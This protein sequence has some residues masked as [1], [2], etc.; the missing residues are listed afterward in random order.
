MAQKKAYEVENFLKTRPQ[1][2]KILL[3]YG[4]DKGLAAEYAADFAKNCGIKPDDPFAI[5]KIDSDRLDKNP[6]ALIDEAQ[7][8]GFFGGKKVVW[9]A[10]AG[11]GA[12]DGLSE[13]LKFLLPQPLADCF[14][15]IEAGDLKKGSALRKIIEEAPRA[16]ALPC[17]SDEGQAIQKLIET[18]LQQFHCTISDEARAVLQANLGNDRLVSRGELEKLCLYSRETGHI[19]VEAVRNSVSDERALSQ[20]EV[21]DAVICGDISAFNRNFDRQIAGGVPAFVILSAVMRQFQQFQLFRFI[22]EEDHKKADIAIAAA[23][24][25]V[26][27]KRRKILEQAL[28]LWTSIKINHAIEKLHKTLLNS[29]KNGE[30]GLIIIRQSLL[31][32]TIAAK[33]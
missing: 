7:T 1:S 2:Y 4:P 3:I 9:V 8:I 23:R 13:A 15:V 5:V 12:K 14:I 30:L 18:V 22:M 26:F 29:R 10:Y 16:M 25:P 32:L 31:A 28:S 17:Y 19:D 24:P 20:N 11:S 27:F 33:R 6:A 21:T